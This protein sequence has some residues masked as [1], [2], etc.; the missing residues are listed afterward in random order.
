V[1][2]FAAS[3]AMRPT[4]SA[5]AK[6][7]AFQ[8]DRLWPMPLPN[9]WVYGSI[10]GLAIDSRDHIFVATRPGSVAAG[11]EA[12][13]MSNP[14][15]AEHCCLAAP[16]IMEFDADGKLVNNWGGAGTGYDWPI[17]TGGIALDNAGNLWITA[18]GIPEPAAAAAGATGVVPGAR[19]ATPPA[20]RATPPVVAGAE[21]APVAAAPGRGGNTPAGP[22]DAHILKF[23]RDGKFLQQIGKPGQNAK[24]NKANLD[25]PADIAIDGDELFVADGGDHQRVVVLDA[26][27]GAFKREWTGHSGPF[28]R[29]SSIAVAKDGSVY[30]G[31]RKGNNV[32]IFKKDGT[33]VKQL[34]VA[35]GTLANGSVWDVGFSSDAKQTWL[36]VA[37][38]QN[39]T[40]RVFN[41]STLAAAGTIGDGGRWPGRFYA[42]NNVAMDSKGNLYTGEGY[43]GK[44]VQKFLKK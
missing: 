20:G 15:T 21:G 24:D 1:T 42:V 13:L 27:T 6:G 44:R 34:D 23:S 33:F 30:V 31:D 36:F 35:K 22:P 17:S 32:Q 16:P 37:D 5:Q 39:S 3:G 41:R 18:A 4:V 26:A 7:P 8:V 9:H 43:E 11:N 19:G 25:R 14:P 40:V 29:I 12:G 28:Q 10:T 2:L 38:G